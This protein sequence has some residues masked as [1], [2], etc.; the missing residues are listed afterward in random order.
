LSDYLSQFILDNGGEVLLGYRVE[1]IIV[2]NN[3]A[4]GVEFRKTRS[5]NTETKKVFADEIIA[6]AS[7]PNVVNNLLSSDE[8]AVLKAKTMELKNLL[9]HSFQYILVLRNQ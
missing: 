5:D 8:A 7:V 9:A 4:I 2:E 3:R 6:N 1:K